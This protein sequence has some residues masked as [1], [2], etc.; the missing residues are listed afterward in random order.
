MSKVIDSRIVQFMT[1]GKIT[2]WVLLF[3]AVWISGLGEYGFQVV[4]FLV[5][6][7]FLG[8]ILFGG[9]SLARTW[10]M[11]L[12]GFFFFFKGMNKI[13]EW[14]AW[15]WYHAYVRFGHKG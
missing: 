2:A 5:F 7:I 6:I 8:A 9:G 10:A 14:M 1:I 3:L 13:G 11:M 4:G 15:G 12:A